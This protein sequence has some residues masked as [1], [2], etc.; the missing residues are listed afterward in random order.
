MPTPADFRQRDAAV[1]FDPGPLAIALTM[2]DAWANIN[3]TAFWPVDCDP[4][5][6]TCDIR[7]TVRDA[8]NQADRGAVTVATTRACVTRL[9]V[10]RSKAKRGEACTLMAEKAKVCGACCGNPP[11]LH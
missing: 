10:P 3:A 5:C 4:I 6:W 9:T 2:P 7:A 8:E 1:P 11:H